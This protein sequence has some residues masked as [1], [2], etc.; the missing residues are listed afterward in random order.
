MIMFILK[1]QDTRFSSGFIASWLH[2]DLDIDLMRCVK[3]IFLPQFSAQHYLS[4][5]EQRPICHCRKYTASSIKICRSPQSVLYLK[6]RGEILRII[7]DMHWQN[8]GTHF[9]V[10]AGAIIHQQNTPCCKTLQTKEMM[11]K[12]TGNYRED[13]FVH[14]VCLCCLST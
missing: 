5:A 8:D 7:F 11:L 6:Y 9:A 1:P 13:D 14:S 4:F 12:L 3:C 2:A 10:F